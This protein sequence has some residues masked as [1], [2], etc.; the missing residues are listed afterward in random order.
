MIRSWLSGASIH[1]NGDDTLMRQQ[2]FILDH[3]PRSVIRSA[4]LDLRVPLWM[5]MYLKKVLEA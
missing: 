4:L 2:I 3:D 5:D 1:I